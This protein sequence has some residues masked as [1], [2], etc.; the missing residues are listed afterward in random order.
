MKAR[1]QVNS[2]L[3]RKYFHLKI[4]PTGKLNFSMCANS[5]TDTKQINQNKMSPVTCHLSPVTCHLSPVTCHLSPVTCHLSPV[6]C[7]L[8]PVT[9][10]LSPVT[11]HL[12]PVTCHLSPVTCQL[13][14]VTCHLS[15]VT[16][17]RSPVTCHL[18]PVNCHLSPVTC[19]LS[20]VTC[21]LLP[22]TC[23]LSPVTCHLSR[24]KSDTWHVTRDMWHMTRF[25]GWTFSQNFSSLALTVC[26]LWY[27]EDLEEKDDSNNQWMTRLF[28]GQPRLPSLSKSCWPI[29]LRLEHWKSVLSSCAVLGALKGAQMQDCP[30]V[31]VETVSVQCVVCSLQC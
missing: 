18:S 1:I 28:V 10:H 22:V 21:H 27:Y 4:L 5:S 11:C 30:I 23:H 16:C 14:P 24:K 31:A 12:S 9:C 6:T 20:P 3:S 17:H 26:D 8:S 19:H 7:H 25:G 29:S 13:S 2:T 15:P